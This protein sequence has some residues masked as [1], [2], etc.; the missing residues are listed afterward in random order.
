MKKVLLI[1]RSEAG[2]T[3]LAQRLLGE[4]P[5][6]HKTQAVTLVGPIIDTPGEYCQRAE[7]AKALALYA[8]EADVVALVVS[9]DEPFM[10]F[11][12]GI[13]SLVNREV[14]GVVTGVDKP[15]ARP[16]L[17]DSWLRL[18]GCRRL[19][20]MDALHGEGVGELLDY[21]GADGSPARPPDETKIRR[22]PAEP[23]KTAK[24]TPKKVPKQ[25]EK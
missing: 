20:H 17:C 4:E 13:T 12:P 22:S 3:T 18:C 7:Y 2:K 11:S 24:K 10:L 5:R 21:L 9:A 8:Y 1:G 19:F 23:I 14:V 15:G 25:T 6:Y 16:D